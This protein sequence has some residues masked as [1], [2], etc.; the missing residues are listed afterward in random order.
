M[1]G[2]W[3]G[4]TSLLESESL[5]LLLLD[6]GLPKLDGVEVLR[7]VHA[8]LLN[9]S[10]LVLS[11]RGQLQEKLACLELGA[12]DYMVK[13]FSLQEL[14]A[15][16][17]TVTRRHAGSHVGVLSNGLLQMDRIGRVVTFAGEPIVFTTKEFSLLEYLL[18][19]CGRSVTR[20]ELLEDAWHMPSDAGTNVVDV[21]VNYLRRKLASAGA[22]DLIE[23][24]RGEGYTLRTPRKSVQ[25]SHTSLHRTGMNTTYAATR[26]AA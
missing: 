20:K 25:S 11:V 3:G 18:L 6:L 9:V 4:G 24:V 2:G 22:I 1:R 19:H 26:G 7:Q 17:R 12:D 16:C 8:R 14:M 10:V 21:Y 5:D 23:T 13:P 15:R